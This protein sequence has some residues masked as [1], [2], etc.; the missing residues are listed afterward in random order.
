MSIDGNH[1]F[2]EALKVIDRLQKEQMDNVR[3]AAKVITKSIKEDGVVH[4]FGSGHSKAFGMELAG[5]AGGLAMMDPMKLEDLV[6]FAEEPMTYEELRHRDTER[7]PDNGVKVMEQHEIKDQDVIIV[8]SNS[9]RNGAV[10]EV[11]LEG[12][13]RGLPIIAVTSLDHSTKTTS[14]HPSGQK[15]YE[16][17]DI[18]IDNCGPYGDALMEVPEMEA[19]ICSISSITNGFIAQA[20]TA[21]IIG[22]LLEDDIN[23]PVFI[24]Y[25]VDGADEHNERLKEKY[26]GRVII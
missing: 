16:I 10:V 22:K 5:R 20:L 9:G 14:R 23:P 24:S 17:A 2:E 19:R 1:F 7:N 15:L 13:R 6:F 4:I 3:K 8:C 12:K 11:A 26:E 25:N 18:V 21:E